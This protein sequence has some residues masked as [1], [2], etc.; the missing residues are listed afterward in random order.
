[1][2]PEARQIAAPV[3]CSGFTVVVCTRDRAH[4]LARALESLR[5]QDYP[6]ERFEIL[7]V[8]NGSRDG[9]RAVVER[10]LGTG[11]VTVRYQL[12]PQAGTSIA[13]NRGAQCARHD[14]VAYLDDDAVALPGWLAAYDRAIREHGA[15]AAGGPVKPVL[16]VATVP[17]PWWSDASIRAIFGLDHAAAVN[18][19]A[20]S[21]ITWPLWLAGGNCVYARALLLDHGGFRTDLGH[22][23][24][25][26][27]VA[28]DIELNARLER[29][30]VPLHYVGGALIEHAVTAERL[31]RGH[32]WLR[33]YAAGITNA[34]VGAVLGRRARA[35]GA[36]SLLRALARLAL[37]GEPA[38]TRA[39]SHVAYQLGYLRERAR[40]R[41]Q[42]RPSAR[43]PEAGG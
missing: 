36:G 43:A 9:T 11:P 2:V 1:L 17:P 4:V 18:G 29:A 41:Q 7:V 39:G 35:P 13:R 16:P 3:P 31:R 15:V 27:G 12:E 8:D 33:S 21:R 42:P 34:A 24:A 14:Y 22:V 6:A 20:V 26:Y 5:A 30:G 38:R 28:E 25:H 10:Q 32:I 23:G 37:A 19:R 40:L